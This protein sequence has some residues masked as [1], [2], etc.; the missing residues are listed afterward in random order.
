[1][2]QELIDELLRF[3]LKNRLL[4]DYRFDEENGKYLF[5][6]HDQA[7]TWG[8]RYQVTKEELDLCNGQSVY[9]A[10]KIIDTIRRRKIA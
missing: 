7:Q 1:M 9:F 2:H 3:S 8:Y 10:H 4:F 5:T 6:F